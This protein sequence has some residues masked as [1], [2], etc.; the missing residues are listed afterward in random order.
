MAATQ[1]NA[2]SQHKYPVLAVKQIVLRNT[3]KMAMKAV[4]EWI[5]STPD[6]LLCNFLNHWNSPKLFSVYVPARGN[7][8]ATN[9]QQMPATMLPGV[10][11]PL[12]TGC[13]C[14]GDLTQSTWLMYTY[15]K[16]TTHTH[17][18][19]HTHTE[20]SQT[21][22]PTMLNLVTLEFFKNNHSFH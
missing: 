12:R 16:F 14:H 4:W 8:A 20:T 15:T 10:C 13:H 7:I 1:K 17:T 19:T 11:R 22:Y 5:N 9:W 6:L 2:Y 3:Q 21:S 18:H